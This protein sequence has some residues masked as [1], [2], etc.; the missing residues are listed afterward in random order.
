ADKTFKTPID[1]PTAVTQPASRIGQQSAQLNATVNP[2][3]GTVTDCHF[4]WGTGE[5]YGSSIACSSLPGSGT[6]PV[7]VSAQLTGLTPGTTYH[8]RIV[9]ANA[10]GSD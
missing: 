6:S 3:G 2:N 7:P 1:T 5:S 10:G 9:A 8:T 4:D